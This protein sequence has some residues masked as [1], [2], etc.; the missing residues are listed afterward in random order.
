[1]IVPGARIP[2]DRGI[3]VLATQFSERHT[4]SSVLDWDPADDGVP[5]NLMELNSS[6]PE[7]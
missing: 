7:V 1:M 2:D 5:R 4:E 6:G 3:R